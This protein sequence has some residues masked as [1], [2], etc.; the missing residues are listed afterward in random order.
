MKQVLQP[1]Q[2]RHHAHGDLD[3]RE[4]PTTAVKNARRRADAPAPLSDR[5]GRRLAR[6]NSLGAGSREHDDTGALRESVH[7]IGR[8]GMRQALERSD[9]DGLRTRPRVPNR[10]TRL[11]NT[12]STKT[13]DA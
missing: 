5:I 4:H 12:N 13:T 9:V 6:G 2:G 10:D 1:T 7:L 8:I 11:E 3:A